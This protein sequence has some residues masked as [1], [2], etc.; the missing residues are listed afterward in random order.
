MT[1]D[2][3]EDFELVERIFDEL[4][5]DGRVFPLAEIVTLLDN[6]PDLRAIHTPVKQKAAKPISLKAEFASD[7]GNSAFEEI[8]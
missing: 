6:R 1:A 4:Y 8:E 7:K 3:V 2:T 5:G